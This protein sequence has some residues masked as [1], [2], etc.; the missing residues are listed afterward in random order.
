MI[1]PKGTAQRLLS[2]MYDNNMINKLYCK[3]GKKKGH[4]KSYDW[5]KPLKECANIRK[6]QRIV[7]SLYKRLTNIRNNYILQIIN[8]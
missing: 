5:K 1:K 3:F 4:L 2:R 7:K 6:Q 8:E